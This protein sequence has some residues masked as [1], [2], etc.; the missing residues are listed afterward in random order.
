MTVRLVNPREASFDG[1]ELGA[2][3]EAR[4]VARAEDLRRA[5]GD[6]ERYESHIEPGSAQYDIEIDCQD[7]PAAAELALGRDGELTF[8]ADHADGSGVST[9][10]AGDAVLVGRTA[11]FRNHREGVSLATLRFACRAGALGAVPVTITE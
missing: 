9:V 5:R 10:T 1:A 8:V 4:L 11:H 6:G 3:T 2:C 7:V